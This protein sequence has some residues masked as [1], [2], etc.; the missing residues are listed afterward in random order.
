MTTS[1]T[2]R[3]SFTFLEILFVIIIIGILA[4]VSFPALRRTYVDLQLDDCSRQL[5]AFMNY[6]DG[7][8]VAEGT[9]IYLTI[10]PEG[11]AYWAQAKD[12]GSRIR[13]YSIPS[14][15]AVETDQQ[16]MI[17]YPDGSID[18]CTIKLISS[19]GRAITLTTKGVFAGVKS[20]GQQ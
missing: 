12:S 11:K 8:A 1:A 19:E 13:S 10:D 20:Q 6:L 16:Q 14:S 4:G 3:R 5:Q 15:I 9:I 17:F 7:R 18:P 2:G